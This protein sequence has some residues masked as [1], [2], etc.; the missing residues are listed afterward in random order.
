ME[1]KRPTAYIIEKLTVVALNYSIYY[2]KLSALVRACE[3]FQH[4][5]SSKDFVIYTNHESLKHLNGYTCWIK[6]IKM[7]PCVQTR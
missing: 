5:L 6:A 1:D 3:T 7:F 2:K 4:Y